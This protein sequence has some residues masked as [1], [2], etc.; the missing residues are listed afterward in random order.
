MEYEGGDI[1]SHDFEMQAV[2]WWPEE[3]VKKDLTYKGDRTAFEE[4]LKIF[5]RIK[6]KES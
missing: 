2:E 1:T 4:A 6:N 5:K 3:K